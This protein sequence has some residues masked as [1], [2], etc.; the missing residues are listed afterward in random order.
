MHEATSK[1]VAGLEGDPSEAL[2]FIGASL[3]EVSAGT[4]HLSGAV[5][6][7]SGLKG[8]DEEVHLGSGHGPAEGRGTARGGRDGLGLPGTDLLPARA[9]AAQPGA[10]L[11]ALPGPDT[12][13]CASTR[14]SASC[15]CA[16]TR[17][18]RVAIGA[19]GINYLEEDRV[20]G[21]DPLAPF[22][23]RR[24]QARPADARLR[25]L[26]GHRRE[27]HLLD[28]PGRGRGVRGARR[29]TRRHGR[30][31]VP[32]VPAAPARAGAGRA[33]SSSA[34]KRSTAICARLAH[35]PRPRGVRRPCRRGR[36]SGGDGG[37]PPP[38]GA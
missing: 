4:S 19:N 32:P 31:P 30:D 25:A 22:G 23:P 34:P 11:R 6:R 38:P 18:G 17:T 10:H 29:L 20:E 3:T 28:R 12:P 24:R 9:R 33:R 14:G 26:P 1:R 8:E 16:R 37:P 15:S 27:Q 5:R 7:A 13:P 36:G 2:G 35:L 21:E